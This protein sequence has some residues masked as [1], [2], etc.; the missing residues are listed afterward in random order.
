MFLVERLIA[1]RRAVGYALRAMDGVAHRRH[2]LQRFVAVVAGGVNR[3]GNCNARIT[4]LTVLVEYGW[5]TRMF[6]RSGPV[7]NRSAPHCRPRT[8]IPAGAVHEMPGAR[9]RRLGS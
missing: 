6:N 2:G 3:V 4:R 7:A 5:R 9:N 1:C 8:A